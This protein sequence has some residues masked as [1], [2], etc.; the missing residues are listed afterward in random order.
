MNRLILGA[1]FVGIAASAPAQPVDRLL[2]RTVYLADTPA[3]PK[4]P[5]PLHGWIDSPDWRVTPDYYIGFPISGWQLDCRDG[6]QPPFVAVLVKEWGD[7]PSRWITNFT[8]ERGLTRPDIRNAYS[9]ACPEIGSNE[10][11]GY[12]VRLNEPLPAGLWSLT[13]FWTTGDGKTRSEGRMAVVR[14]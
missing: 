13:V 14:P 12:T 7:K 5:F 1:L 10:A 8:V 3:I 6:R 2:S 4:P 11:F 9:A